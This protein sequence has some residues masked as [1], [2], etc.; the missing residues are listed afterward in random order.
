MSPERVLGIYTPDHL[1]GFSHGRELQSFHRGSTIL[2]LVF[3]LIKR[4]NH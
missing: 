2:L 1:Q 3:Q 4:R